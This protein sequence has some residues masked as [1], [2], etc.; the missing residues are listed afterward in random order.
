MEEDTLNSTHIA[1]VIPEAGAIA[2]V[3]S[4]A[5]LRAVLLHAPQDIFIITPNV[6]FEK[7]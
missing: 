5:L 7:F 1:L 2:G 4:E 6:K 3:I